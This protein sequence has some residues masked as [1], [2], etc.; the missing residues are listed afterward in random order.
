MK[1]T[2]SFKR[3]MAV[4]AVGLTT[5]LAVSVNALIAPLY[6]STWAGFQSDLSPWLLP[7][8]GDDNGRLLG[9]PLDVYAGEFTAAN[10]LSG[11]S[12]WS[13]DSTRVLLQERLRAP[14]PPN[15][16][17]GVTQKGLEPNRI[18]VAR[19]ER[20]PGKPLPIVPIC[21]LKS[22]PKARSRSSKL[23]DLVIL[24]KNPLTVDPK[25]IKDIKVVET[26]KEG[27]SIY[28]APAR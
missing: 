7:G 14:V 10:N 4:L 19:I 15:S 28:V 6:L 25:T 5:L 12:F 24:D 16:P 26:I 13:P 20:P 21:I 2:P 9:Q 8:T 3:I 17:R 22:R 27:K 23:A 18:V 1:P 11:V